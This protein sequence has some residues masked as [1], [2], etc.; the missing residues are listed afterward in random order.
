MNQPH[1]RRR[2][3]LGSLGAAGLVWTLDAPAAAA[4]SGLVTYAVEGSDATVALLPGHTGDLLLHVARRF[5]YEVAALGAGDAR[6]TGGGATLILA[7]DRFPAG[8][9]GAL[10]PGQVDT[11]RDILADCAGRVRWGGDDRRRPQE[12]RF[13]VVRPGAVRLGTPG[14][15]PDV[16]APARH[17][18]ATALA[19][20]QIAAG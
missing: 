10:F 3:F 16:Y 4:A 14:R 18:A 13:T 7:P 2:T 9:R 15:M 20:R 11:V 19:E 1:L 12:G 6:G 8:L 5:H 17:R